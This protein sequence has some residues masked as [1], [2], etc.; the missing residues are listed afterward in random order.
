MQSNLKNQSIVL[1]S[2]KEIHLIE[3]NKVINI[4]FQKDL[5]IGD[6]GAT[7]ISNFIEQIQQLESLK[8]VFSQNNN[9]SSL[10][11]SKISQSIGKQNNIID[12][13][14][15]IQGLNE[16]DTNGIKSFGEIFEKLKILKS[17]SFCICRNNILDGISF[18]MEGIKTLINL[19]TLILSFQRNVNLGSSFMKKVESALQFIPNLKQLNIS[20]GWQSKIGK[21]GAQ[22]LGVILQNQK[23]LEFLIINIGSDNNIT[24]DGLN[25]ISQGLK[26]LTKLKNLNLYIGCHIA[27]LIK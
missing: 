6:K 4:Q 26:F 22:S 19:E 12:L 10:G 1:K 24:G 23:N 2:L 7:V 5:F 15:E 18:L 3:Y 20:L 21:E 8:L 27:R 17:L 16:I 11:L 14:I 13:S 25:Y 9:L